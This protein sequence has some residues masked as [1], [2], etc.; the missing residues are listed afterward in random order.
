MDVFVHMFVISGKKAR[1]CKIKTS[2]YYLS[3]ILRLCIITE[4]K[5]EL[6]IKLLVIA[7]RTASTTRCFCVCIY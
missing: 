7:I 3:K 2:R 5:V 1:K 4:L 6:V